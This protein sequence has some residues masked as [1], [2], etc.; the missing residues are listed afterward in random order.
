MAL[1]KISGEVSVAHATGDIAEMSVTSF[2]EVGLNL[3]LIDE[4]QDMV[5]YSDNSNGSE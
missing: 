3:G 1:K 5:Y 2:Y 4:N